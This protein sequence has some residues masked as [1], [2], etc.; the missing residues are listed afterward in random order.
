MAREEDW[1]QM[2]RGMAAAMRE[3]SVAVPALLLRH[4]KAL[5]L[6]DTEAMLLIH[7][8]AFKDKEG[9][10]FPTP[11]ELAGRMS[12]PPET[13][14]QALQ[15][16][17]KDET[18]QIDEYTDPGTGVLS[19]RY[20]LTPLYRKLAAAWLE[21]AWQN[22]ESKRDAAAAPVAGAGRGQGSAAAFGQAAAAAEA[23]AAG[24]GRK[25]A[26]QASGKE[27]PAADIF[28]VFEQEFARPLT[29]MECET[30][31]QW[32]DRDRYP[33]ELILLALKEAVFA[34]VVH[35]RYIDRILLEWS[36]NRIQTAEQA[37]EYAQ[38][39]RGAR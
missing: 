22:A 21:E 7:L 12:A 8:L 36:R 39:F 37:K 6:S 3:G 13:V 28:T 29:P 30:I 19:E 20:N 25:S 15:R 11:D 4:Y 14:L 17:L 2:E 10:E 1:R 26:G 35:F 16:L 32:L 18:L 34:G 24:K 31:S 9:K 23:K 27:T 5:K 33:E 38:K